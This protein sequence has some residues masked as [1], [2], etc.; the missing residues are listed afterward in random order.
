MTLARRMTALAAVLAAAALLAGADAEAED[1]PKLPRFESF[2][3]DDVNMR[4]GPST[5]HAVKWVY[6]RKGLPVE[7]LAEFEVWRRVRDSDGEIGWVHVAML[8]RER[9]ALIRGRGNAIL[10]R[11]EDS[12]S[13]IVAEA[14]PGA[15]GR[16]ESCGPIACELKFGKVEG[17]VDR[18]RLWG[19]YADEHF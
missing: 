8:S 16:I 9:M 14:A 7:V 1:A 19:V 5:G 13:A 6:H 12:T 2:K 17:W 11:R 4:E 10:R 18:A 3:S 15:I